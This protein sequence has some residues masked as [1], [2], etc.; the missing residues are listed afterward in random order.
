MSADGIDV[1][2]YVEALRNGDDVR[3]AELLRQIGRHS[4]PQIDLL[5]Q[6]ARFDVSSG[7]LGDAS[8][9]LE[10]MSWL[11][12]DELDHQRRLTE[13]YIET[14]RTDDALDLL[15][16]L[17]DHD[18]TIGFGGWRLEAVLRLGEME[19]AHA[20]I[21]DEVAR[22]R[23][24]A[25]EI[26]ALRALICFWEGLDLRALDL[27]S[28][29]V[30]DLAFAKHVYSRVL[31]SQMHF[32]AAV[33]YKRS[34]ALQTGGGIETVLAYY[35][36]VFRLQDARDLI[37][38][39][40]AKF[41]WLAPRREEF[42]RPIEA[43]AA[44]VEDVVSSQG[45]PDYSDRNRLYR[46]LHENVSAYEIEW[47]K[48]SLVELT[49]SGDIEEHE[50]GQLLRP[51]ANW[52][53][54]I[55][56]TMCLA[57]F[58]KK[59]PDSP[60]VRQSYLGVLERSGN[61]VETKVEIASRLTPEE[62]SEDIAF[63]AIYNI[64]R[65]KD[66]ANRPPETDQLIA[67]GIAAVRGFLDRADL[68]FLIFSHLQ[69]KRMGIESPL[70]ARLREQE[71]SKLLQDA[72]I[73][74]H[75]SWS[76]EGRAI[77]GVVRTHRPKIVV[78]LSG[79]M[80]GFDRCWERTHRL[81]VK[82]LG[83]P[84]FLSVWNQS[85]NA[86][87]RHA[88]RL[89]R[90]LPADILARMPEGD[91]YTDAFSRNYPKTFNLVFGKQP[92]AQADVVRTVEASGVQEYMIETE[93][94]AVYERTILNAAYLNAHTLLKM[95]AKFFALNRMMDQ[96]ELVTGEAITH[97][98]WIRPDAYLGGFNTELLRRWSVSDNTIWSSVSSTAV[99]DYFIFMPR[100]ALRRLAE[101]FSLSATS[102]KPAFNAWLPLPRDISSRAG[103][104]PGIRGPEHIAYTLFANGFQFGNMPQ[105]Q[106]RL[107]GHMP[108]DAVV[109]ETF[110]AEYAER[111]G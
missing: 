49:N 97:V 42:L 58:L 86:L 50:L 111:H 66:L 38:E 93:D 46:A 9:K 63:S 30:S 4:H 34:Y 75:R 57:A 41:S 37:D 64:N 36:E 23:F 56:L 95:Y 12:P 28:K 89:Q 22:N 59:F 67:A 98:A 82:P 90:A 24:N 5:S 107:L 3:A 61:S 60:H 103:Y 73:Q 106:I 13:V 110:N 88:N 19:A 87:G 26:D 33:E 20:L 16:R 27:V 101:V 45:R 52:E 11:R 74:G 76:S 2:A 91:R 48:L 65:L 100:T 85:Q 14:G 25:T 31:D 7:N 18:Q 109:R 104:T 55:A 72:A 1:N 17:A 68:G 40:I 62:M 15:R 6:A 51:F 44:L 10:I 80:R 102:G 84:V 99:L 39:M 105:T 32:G 83:A 92:I 81:L 94:E 47:G 29:G 53:I 79:Q 8:A 54:G 77:K 108:P 78:A 96:H 21:E 71:T 69:L 70:A 35:V 43:K